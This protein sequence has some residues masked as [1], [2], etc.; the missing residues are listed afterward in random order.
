MGGGGLGKYKK[1]LSE[2]TEAVKKGGAGGVWIFWLKV[3]KN[4]Y[5]FFDASPKPKN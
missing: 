5:F 1:S 3:K 2:N 4:Q